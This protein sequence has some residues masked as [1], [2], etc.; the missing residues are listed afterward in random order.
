MIQISFN[1]DEKT[2]TVNNIVVRNLTSKKENRFPTVEVKENKLVISPKAIGMIGCIT[3]DRITIQYFQESPTVTFPIIG[4]SSVFADPDS[5][6]KLT[7]S[8]TVSFKGFQRKVLI[9]YG[10]EFVLEPFQEGMFK[11][12]PSSSVTYDIQRVF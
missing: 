4:L 3:G 5:G 1:Y 9:Q 7:K 10:T 2:N 11:M 6:N 8:N 12:V